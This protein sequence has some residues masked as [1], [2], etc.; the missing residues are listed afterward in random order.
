MSTNL[1]LAIAC[2]DAARNLAGRSITDPSIPRHSFELRNIVF[3][4]DPDHDGN[5][6]VRMPKSAVFPGICCPTQ[7]EIDFALDILN[8]D[9]YYI[10]VDYDSVCGWFTFQRV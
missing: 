6:V 5:Y 4:I 1:R 7:Q 9:H 8:N 10:V 2:I 3:V